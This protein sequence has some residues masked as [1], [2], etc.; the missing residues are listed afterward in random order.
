ML[1]YRYQ[2]INKLSL[3]NLS[4]KMNWVADPFLFNDPFEFTSKSIH[5]FDEYGQLTKLNEKHQEM[6]QILL[7][8]INSYG[9]IS[10]SRNEKNHLMWSH[11]AD[12]H[13]GM[14]LV[15]DVPNPIKM[16]IRKVKYLNKL[17]DINYGAQMTELN[18][19]LRKIITIKS[20]EWRYEKEYRQILIDKNLHY[21]YPGKL[22][23][24]VFGCRTSKNDIE[25]VLNIVNANNED[26]IISK[27]GIQRN[28]F[29]LGKSTMAKIKDRNYIVPSSW[30][31][32]MEM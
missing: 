23:E 25:L 8:Q 10:Y 6:R 29:F 31:G 17:P 21:Q 11:Y 32:K 4:K 22:V 3:M 15:F 9:V 19:E 13:K 16:G 18:K 1:F 30:D 5:F 20:K 2:P 28:T 7:D 24:I 27:K 26:L 14:C 12:H